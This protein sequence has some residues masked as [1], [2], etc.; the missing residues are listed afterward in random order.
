MCVRVRVRVCVCVCAYACACVCVRVCVHVHVCVCVCGVQAKANTHPEQ[1]R[2]GTVSRLGRDSNPRAQEFQSGTLRTKLLG[3]SA[4]SKAIAML[5]P[6][7]LPHGLQH[8]S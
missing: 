2:K 4:G 3:S 1:N 5:L 8:S 7:N 6:I